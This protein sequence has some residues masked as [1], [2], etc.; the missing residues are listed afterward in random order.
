[1]HRTQARRQ[2]VE[3]KRFDEVIVGT[4]IE[5]VDAIGDRAP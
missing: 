4:R 2:F 5:A 3:V 1:M